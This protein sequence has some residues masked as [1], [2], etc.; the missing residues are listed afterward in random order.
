MKIYDALKTVALFLI[1]AGL[2]VMSYVL[3]DVMGRHGR[4][5]PVSY[6]DDMVIVMDTHTGHVWSINYELKETTSSKTINSIS[7]KIQPFPQR[8]T[9]RLDE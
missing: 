9:A 3:H 1:A 2:F 5:T 8:L 6:D 7:G 4:Y